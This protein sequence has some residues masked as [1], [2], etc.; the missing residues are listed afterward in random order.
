MI[1]W[2]LWAIWARYR[3]LRA[4]DRSWAYEFTSVLELTQVFLRAFRVPMSDTTLGQ[5][6]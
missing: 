5:V 3:V 1:G 2:I 6:A 4:R